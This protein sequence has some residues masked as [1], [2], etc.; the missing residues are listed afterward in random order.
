MSVVANVAINVDATKALQQLR[1]VETAS[2]NVSGAG[3]QMAQSLNNATNTATSGFGKLRTA[4]SGIGGVIASLGV[5]ALAKSFIGTGIEADRAAKRIT[6]LTGSAQET[7]RVQQIA[8]NA[9]K[10]FGIGN[11]TASQGVADL[12]A[13]LKPMGI[14]TKDIEAAYIGVNKA[15]LNMGLTGEATSNVMLQ[16]SQA[17]GSG[18]LQGDEFRSVAEQLP[19]VMDAVAKVM[20]VSRAELKE[21][22]SEGKITTEVLIQ[23]MSELAKTNTVEPDAYRQFQAAMEN[24][25]VTIG[26]KLLPAIT[27]L[28]QGLTSIV[29][30]FGQLPQP[31]QTA[32]VALGAVVA[33]IA[34]LAP[35]VSTIAGA[36]A[37]LGPVF[38][39]VGSAI[40]AV[41]AAIGGAGGL[42]AVIGTVL[43]IISGPVGWIALIA[44][45]GAAMYVFRDNIAEAMAPIGKIFQQAF[46]IF[47]TAF[48]DPILISF[49]VIKKGVIAL[50]E[51]IPQAFIDAW[52]AAT[53]AIRD[54]I[55]G[56]ISLVE[57]GLNS[58][59]N[60]INRILAEINAS[61]ARAGLPTIPLVPEVELER[62]AKGGYV[63]KPTPA[64]IG[65]GGEPE[66]V[67]PA[68]KMERALA[69]YAAG[70]RG[71]QVLSPQVNI[72]T[73]P[74][75]QMDGTNYVTMGDLR[76]ATSAAARQ[77]ANLALSQL[78]ND[79]SLRRSLGV[80]R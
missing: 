78:Q 4:I 21:L 8:A 49:D 7:A 42:T 28:V 61:L 18:K 52:K 55:N 79:P 63:N 72:T 26:T 12:Y 48:V 75:T 11:L 16:L 30:A 23:A 2:K 3:T 74:V 66:Y 32:I 67:I 33:A 36:V 60:G 1:A 39:G 65:E 80:A 58:L 17:L 10:A 9:A 35:V 57:K 64:L 68:S 45:A 70:R 24:L 38:A 19:P 51:A 25:S 50:A 40:A 20:G 14:A 5:A 31:V 43:G 47:K 44:A 71:A 37:A 73:G 59:V 22:G 29:N 54:A 53:N 77:G 56:V 13:R 6:L 15:A 62:F 34:V 69:N 27:P 46:D 41:T 76:Q